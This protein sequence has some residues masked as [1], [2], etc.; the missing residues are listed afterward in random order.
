MEGQKLDRA[1][2]E[3]CQ[4]CTVITCRYKPTG[5]HVLPYLESLGII[6]VIT[7][8]DSLKGFVDGCERFIFKLRE[9]TAWIGCMDRLHG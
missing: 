5:T 9:T 2:P 8:I 3:S 1:M 7:L 4:K 6:G